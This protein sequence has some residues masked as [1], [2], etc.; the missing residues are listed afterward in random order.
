MLT[1]GITRWE[2][3]QRVMEAKLTRLAHKIAIQLHLMAESCSVCRSRSRLP[4]RELLDT[5]SWKLHVFQMSIT[6]LQIALVFLPGYR[7]AWRPC[8]QRRLQSQRKLKKKL[9][10]W[11]DFQWHDVHIEF[12]W[13]RSVSV[14]NTDICRKCGKV[15]IF[16]KGSN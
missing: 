4:I 10:I 14:C 15:Q 12:H 16:G 8:W 5:P 1:F 11:V 9:L 6:N 13:S 7:F 2:A 3:T